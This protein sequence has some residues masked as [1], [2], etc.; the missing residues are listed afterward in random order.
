MAAERYDAA[1]RER[2]WQEKWD[3]SAVFAADE[4]DPRPKYYVLEMFPYPSGRIHIGHTRNYTMGDV[5]ARF[6]RARGHNVLHPMGWDAF[7]MPAENAAI[8]RGIHPGEWTYDN[9]ATMRDQLKLM[10]F[11]ID[12]SREL[13]T[14][15]V[16]YYAQ[17]QSLFV[18]L[19][20]AG[21]V[22]RKTRKVNWD[23]VD[24]TVL[25]NEQVIDGKGWRSGAP[26]EQ[27]ELAQWFFKI[28]EFADELLEGLE[29]LERWPEKVRLMQS[30]WIGRSEGMLVLFETI[31]ETAPENVPTIQVFTTRPDTLFGASFLAIAADHPLASA[32]GQADKTAADF[33]AECQR[34]G[35]S[36]A[37]LETLEKQGY[38]TGVRVAHPVIE[39]ATLPVYIANFILSEYGTGAIFGCPAHDQRDLEFARKYDLPV[40]PVVLPPNEDEGSFA[41]GDEAYTGDGTMIN[42][43]FLNGM[44]VPAAKAAMSDRL[45]QQTVRNIQQGERKIQF[46]LRD[47]GI[48]RQRYWGCP[49]P[50][51]HCETCG[52]VPVPKD[53]LPVELPNDVS[54]DKPGNPL[55][56]HP[57]WKIVTCPSCGGDARRETDTMDTFVDS[58]W[59]FARF[60][61]PRA[62]TP[63]VPEVAD[64]WLPVDQ[65]IGGIEHAILHLL[66]ARFFTR[67]MHRTGHVGLDEPFAGLFTQGM[68]THE[69]YRTKDGQWVE[70]GLVRIEDSEGD[71][72]AVHAETGEEIA[73]GALEKMSKSKKNTVGPEEIVGQYGADTARWFMLSDTPPE[74]DIQW[75]ESG[76]EGSYRF[77]QR[78]WRMTG[79]VAALGDAPS[80]V[81]KDISETAAELRRTTHKTIAA[82]TASIENLRFNSAVAQIYELSNALS[83]ALNKAGKSLDAGMHFALGEATRTLARLAAPMVPHL[84]EECWAML[85]HHGLLTEESWP[86][87]DPA[88]VVDDQV[89]IAVQVNGKRRDEL[90][91]ARDASKED[92]EAAAL[93]LE[94]VARAIGGREIK[95]IVV[96]PQ[97]IVNVVA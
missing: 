8:E 25:A 14:C 41:I 59:Y 49:I 43:D 60:T 38:D 46:R 96:V 89:T 85:G 70:P 7:G 40:T 75:T 1:A 28:T 58:S 29:S 56:H 10:G 37:E 17:Q 62:E 97:R 78:V 42:S 67:A 95:K 82:V 39:G 22:E 6:M 4:A 76:V 21:L 63:T 15:D 36:A 77:L 90:T 61:A 91:I 79:E 73:I 87:P 12:W 86:S 64:E 23:P 26:V 80:D 30:N 34:H 51:I 18:D 33:I 16:E 83:A 9:I 66:Y 69:T 13:A 48:S 32:V 57:S 47:W 31:A 84:A 5:V 54:F 44:D 81:P 93:K 50:M 94:N 2:Y 27:R 45:E 71:R 11:S 72:K 52:I 20:E 92:I 65:Y 68:V 74:R 24:Q 19:L 55:D 88:L 3:E 53:T 35:T